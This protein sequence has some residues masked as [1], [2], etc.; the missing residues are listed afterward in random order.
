L[1]QEVWNSSQDFEALFWWTINKTMHTGTETHSKP[2][3]PFQQDSYNWYWNFLGLDYL[4]TG[5]SV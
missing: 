1:K 2:M 3:F 4:E 5:S